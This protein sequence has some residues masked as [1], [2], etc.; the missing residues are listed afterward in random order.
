MKRAWSLAICGLAFFFSHSASARDI[1]VSS[2]TGANEAAGSKAAPKKLLWKV[3]AELADGDHIYV[4]EGRQEGQNKSGLMPQCGA[5]NVVIE[6]GWNKDFSARNPFK[7]P[8]IIA[9]ALDQGGSVGKVI[10]FESPSNKIDNVTIDG[11]L[12]DRG[13]SNY[14]FSDGEPGANKRIEGHSDN[15]PWGYRELNRKSS[16]SDPAVQL[17]GRGR[18]VVRNMIIVNSPWWGIY[19]KAGGN[20]TTEIENNLVLISQGRGIEAIPGGGWDKPNFVIRNNTVAFNHSLKSTEGRALST[21][22]REATGTYVVE[23]NVLAFSD[24]AGLATKF[25]PKGSVLTLKNN[26]FAFNRLGDYTTGGDSGGT[27]AKDFNDNLT[28]THS[29]NV[30]E[31]PKFTSKL[32]KEWFDRWSSREYVDMV[33]GT[34][35]T[36]AELMAARGALGLKDYTI[37][38][39]DKTYASY[40]TLPQKRN[41]YDMSRYP[42]PMKKGDGANWT[43]AVLGI[44]GADGGRGI[45]PF[46]AK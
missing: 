14:Y 15:S 8:T 39:Y 32:A 34:F 11:F 10:H 35:N 2:E 30:H 41:N 24:G 45:Q 3:M 25:G 5:S 13:G 38:G 40:K 37:P 19:V 23:N 26:L 43:S 6:G 20:G 33:A 27:A 18:F 7:H 28:I 36:E 16:G 22:P 29:G 31:L 44:I 9:A 4:A 1:Y 12:I 42:R 21:D 46:K 17:I